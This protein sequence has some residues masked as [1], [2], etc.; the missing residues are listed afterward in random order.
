M[1]MHS[2]FTAAP[3]LWLTGL[4]GAGKSTLA[5][6]LA[7]RFNANGVFVVVLDGDE[8]RHGVSRDLG[9]S[10]ADRS[11]N[12]RRVAEMCR[13]LNSQG[14]T[15]VASLISPYAAD[16]KIAQN[17]V[18]TESFREIFLSTPLPVCESRDPK[19][20]Y[21]MAR[22]GK[23]HN[24]TGIDSRYEPPEAPDLTIDATTTPV[25]EAVGRVLAM[26]ERA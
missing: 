24:F 17:I 25:H 4:S 8:V 26:L 21:R 23:I 13:L 18:G 5:S 3:T 20:L 2:T 19:G 10:H 9:F 11:E 16:R 14:V 6:A 1:V 22:A 12:I 7:A 15:A